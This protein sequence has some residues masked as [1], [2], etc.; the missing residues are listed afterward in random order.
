MQIESLLSEQPM[1]LYR[2]SPHLVPSPAARPGA[3]AGAKVPGYRLDR[4]ISDFVVQVGWLAGGMGWSV[5]LMGTV[6]TWA[7]CLLAWLPYFH[8][9]LVYVHDPITRF[10][11][12]NPSP[13]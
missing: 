9:W 2:L 3:A 4:H 5:W 7:S 11:N 6:Q 8:A 12:T 1:A 13:P 10:Y